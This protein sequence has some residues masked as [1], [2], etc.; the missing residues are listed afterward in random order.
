MYKTINDLKFSLIITFIYF[1][2]GGVFVTSF[3]KFI[4]GSL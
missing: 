1:S 3:F 4:Q 2:V